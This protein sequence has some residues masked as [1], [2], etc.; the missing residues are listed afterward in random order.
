MLTP[1]PHYKISFAQN[2]EDVFLAG[3]F[4]EVENGFYVDVGANHPVLDSVTKIFYDK[5]WSGINIEPNKALHAALS[6]QRPRDLNLP[7]G[8]S[9]Q[10]GTLTFRNYEALDGLSSC[11]SESQENILAYYPDAKFSDVSI[12]ISTLTQVF[13]THRPTGDIHFL[14]I[15]VEG[16][17]LEVLLGNDWK[18]YRPWMLCIERTQDLARRAAISAFLESTSYTRVHFDGINDYH[19]AAEKQIIWDNFSY[20]RDVVMGGVVVNHIFVNCIHSLIDENQT[21]SAQLLDL[22]ARAR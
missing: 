22:Q 3:V 8:L 4:R 12:D 2:F 13:A 9:S 21:I 14:K 15:D 10:I 7:I 20:A 16:L 17:E 1:I 19:V 18:H 6:E 11:S 5:G